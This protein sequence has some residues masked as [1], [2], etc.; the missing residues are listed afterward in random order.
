MYCR[1]L[2]FWRGIKRSVSKW[3]NSHFDTETHI[4]DT[5][6][7]VYDVDWATI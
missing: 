1:Y 5:S 3:R 4:T 6:C 7:V 2:G